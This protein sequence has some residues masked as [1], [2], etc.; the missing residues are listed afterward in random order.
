[1]NKS[2]QD[3]DDPVD[4]SVEPSNGLQEPQNNGEKVAKDSE[5][6]D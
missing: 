5:Q 1:M 6:D 2:C 4:T 3:L